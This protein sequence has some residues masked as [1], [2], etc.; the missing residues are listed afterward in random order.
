MTFARVGEKPVGAPLPAPIQRRD[1]KTALPQLANDL[2]IFLDHFG[3][4]AEEANRPAPRA[5]RIPARVAQ[6]QSIRGHDVAGHGALGHRVHRNAVECH[7]ALPLPVARMRAQHSVTTAYF[8]GQRS[9][10]AVEVDCPHTVDP[11]TLTVD[12]E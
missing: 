4:A 6:L 2:E 9:T 10:A 7:K 11:A 8:F 12:D 3:A 1:G 5:G